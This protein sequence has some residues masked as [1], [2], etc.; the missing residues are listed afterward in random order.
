MHPSVGGTA[1]YKVNPLNATPPDAL[2][3]RCIK[4]ACEYSAGNPVLNY[5]LHVL[6][7]SKNK[8]TNKKAPAF[9]M[10]SS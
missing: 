1:L 5:I 10:F 4:S 3:G 9:Y 8:Q 2:K 6:S 7:K